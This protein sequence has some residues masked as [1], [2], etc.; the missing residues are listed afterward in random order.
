ME[1]EWF[2]FVEIGTSDFDTEIQACH[3]NDK[4][5]SIEPVVYYL[6]RLP[7]N[8]KVEKLCVAISDTDG[9]AMVYSVTEETIQKYQLPAWVKGCSSIGAPHPTVEQLFRD[10]QLQ[11]FWKTLVVPKWSFE[12]LAINKGIKRVKY[13]KISA[14]GHD[15][16][17]MRAVAIAIVKGLLHRPLRICFET[18][19]LTAV[20][21]QKEIV[22]TFEGMGYHLQ[23]GKIGHEKTT[24]FLNPE[25]HLLEATGKVTTL[26][27]QV[28][29]FQGPIPGP[30]L[31]LTIG[32]K[33]PGAL[34]IPRIMH[35]IWV[36]PNGK[37]ATP[38]P[39]YAWEY[40]ADWHRLLGP[41]W[42]VRLWN[43]GDLCLAN[44]APAVL[45]K[46]TLA[47]SGAQKADIMRYH[48]VEQ[49]GGFYMDTDM[50]PFLS[51]DV[52]AGFDT[53]AFCCHEGNFNLDWPYLSM[54]FFGATPGHPWLKRACE[55]AMSATINHKDVHLHTGPRLFGMA[56][57]QK[58][59]E[60]LLL[61]TSWFYR[62]KGARCTIGQTLANHEWAAS[63]VE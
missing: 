32:P 5:L 34:T 49:Y 11:Q 50:K 37:A 44:F 27:G 53:S 29:G 61:P 42:H 59:H 47:N 30:Q 33:G 2:D 51:L 20:D 14:S 21:Q 25:D 4:G 28:K 10:K 52:L 23:G 41:Q 24:L 15:C 8:P 54:G 48:I 1:E 38:P 26:K 39:A 18:N 40:L 3:V 43:D 60:C 16:V 19:S 9:E 13:L 46:I 55:M 63:W 62:A 31:S 17:I 45:E 58:D 35:L 6:N 7:N 36:S 22:C 56:L 12:T 57:D